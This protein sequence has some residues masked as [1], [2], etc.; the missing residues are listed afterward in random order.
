MEG[1]KIEWTDDTWSPWEGCQK[2]S[3]GCK[4]CYAAARDKL[5]HRGENW[6]PEGTR[7]M[8]K[9]AYWDQ[10]RVWNNQAAKLGRIRRVFC[11]SLCDILESGSYL[12]Q[13]RGETFAM[14][15]STP[16][17]MWL[18][19]T[20]RPENWEYFPAEWLEFWPDNAM[21]GF[22]AENDE[23]LLKRWAHWK[24]LQDRTRG[25]RTFISGEPLLSSLTSMPRILGDGGIDWVI[26]GGESQDGAR[27][28]HP[29]WYRGLA[30]ACSLYGVP[31]LHKQW[32]EWLP[33]SQ[34][35]PLIHEQ[36]NTNRVVTIDYSGLV[37][38]GEEPGWAANN[39]SIAS[40]PTAWVGKKAAGR[41]LDGKEYNG[42]P[43]YWPPN[44]GMP[45]KVKKSKN[46]L[47]VIA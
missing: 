31:Y 40:V 5:Y 38:Q 33:Y 18:F 22:T 27:P 36:W 20:K 6:G 37:Q 30:N 1:S 11:G 21:F 34:R 9:A 24:A 44:V 42:L 29:A 16:N 8:H 26:G 15:K 35:N 2:V 32:G 46:P 7:L 19:L 13:P 45:V 17:I 39:K 23:M 47:E 25:L 4:N 14:V 10:I 3:P 43:A 12:D 28:S 41:L